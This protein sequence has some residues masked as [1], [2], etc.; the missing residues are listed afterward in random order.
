MKQS[1]WHGGEEAHL[2]GLRE[3]YE[4]LIEELR[5]RLAESVDVDETERIGDEL[6][7][8]REESQ[9]HR[10]SVGKVLY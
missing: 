6:S 5:R 7:R 1:F 10:E 8:L 9:K 2:R 3:H 4:P